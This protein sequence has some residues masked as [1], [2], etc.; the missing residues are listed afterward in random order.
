MAE[1]ALVPDGYTLTKVSK[2]EKQAV[3]DLRKH[4]TFKTFLDNETTPILIGGTMAVAF[5]PLLWALFFKAL[6]EAGV[7]VSDTQKGVILGGLPAVL[8]ADNILGGILGVGGS[9]IDTNAVTKLWNMITKGEG[10]LD[11]K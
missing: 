1:Y 2:D 7:T 10:S 4:E 5:T 3:K 6:Q 9:A 11:T 8:G